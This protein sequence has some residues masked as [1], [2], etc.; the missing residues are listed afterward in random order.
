M[1]AARAMPAVERREWLEAAA[2]QRAIAYG[3]GGRHTEGGMRY[4]NVP[5]MGGAQLL[6]EVS[7]DVL[8]RL[9]EVR[10]GEEVF[11]MTEPELVRG[12]VTLYRQSALGFGWRKM[13]ASAC[14]YQVRP[15]Q[16]LVLLEVTFVRKGGRSQFAFVESSRPSVV[17]LKGWGHPDLSGEMFT[18]LK[19]RGQMVETHSRHSAFS[20]EWSREFGA[21]LDA[22]VKKTGAQVLLDMRE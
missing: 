15:V 16:D 5:G 19:K 11:W 20:E 3:P 9:A 6:S 8:R 4:L 22:H 14:F 12:K 13:E 7:E 18:P 10:D 2:W 21:A 17:I 1:A